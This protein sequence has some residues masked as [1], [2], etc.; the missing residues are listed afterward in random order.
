M[1]YG[2]V[3]GELE[4]VRDEKFRVFNERI[5]NVLPGSSVGVRVPLLRK[6]AQG[7]VRRADFSFDVLLSFPDEIFEI[8]C[9]KCLCVGYAKTG[10]DELV[11]LIRRCVPV[12]DGW[13]VCDLFCSTLKQIKKYRRPYLEEIRAFVA[14]GS[15]FSQ[16]FAYVLLLGAYVE[17]EWLEEIFVLLGRAKSEYYYTRMG[18]AWLLAEVLVKFYDRGAE[19]LKSG[20]LDASVKSKAIQKACESFRLTADEKK[21]LKSLKN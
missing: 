14:E 8:R 1:E 12:I 9:L 10:Y 21:Y 7:L 4:K 5:V 19:Y 18:A 13:A 2:S 15:E 11:R 20:A 6:Y 3:L 16:R 17:E